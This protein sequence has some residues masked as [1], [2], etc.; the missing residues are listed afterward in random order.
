MKLA[1]WIFLPIGAAIAVIVGL[2]LVFGGFRA[3]KAL[4]EFGDGKR[5]R[6][7]RTFNPAKR[8]GYK[9]VLTVVA[10]L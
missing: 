5:V 6:S 10:V 9:G 8:R 2:T 4:N 1:A 3:R 7:L